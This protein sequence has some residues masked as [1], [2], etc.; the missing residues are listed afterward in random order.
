[1]IRKLSF[2]VLCAF[3]LFLLMGAGVQEDQIA[4]LED[5]A[6]SEV[7]VVEEEVP[8]PPEKELKTVQA[9]SGTDP[10]Q[11]AEKFE[12]G[13]LIDGMSA[14]ADVAME[15]RSGVTYVSLFG[16]SKALDSTAQTG[17]NAAS[18]TASVT[19]GKLAVTAKVG[20]I[21]IQANDRYLYL[22]EGVQMKDGEVKLPL[23]LVAKAFDAQIAWNAERQQVIVTRGSGALTP[24]SVYYDQNNLF[25][26]ER[27]IYLE[28][29][30]QPMDGKIAVGNVVLNRV[31]N[32]IFANTVQGVLAQKNQFSTYRSGAMANA[33]P[34][35]E[36]V[37]AAKLALEGAVVERTRGA[38]WFDSC[39]VSWA[40][41]NRTFVAAIGGHKFYK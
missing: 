14:P 12:S 22:P 36:S 17:W 2:A 11:I 30:N 18:A 39:A 34:N 28:S 35:A 8:A 6:P 41:L 32:P 19:T 23:S 38:L 21:Y 15:V 26:L 25:W 16:M 27:V 37:I 5:A 29:G 33:Q 40:S 7:T 10:M 4:G 3:A 20:Q 1:M 9:V 24:G 31:A 13:M